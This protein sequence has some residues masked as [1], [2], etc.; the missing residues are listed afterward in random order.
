MKEMK[1]PDCGGALRTQVDCM[2]HAK[3]CPGY[4]RWL[5]ERNREI[6]ELR[7]RGFGIRAIAERFG[8]SP[9]LVCHVLKRSAPKELTLEEVI[10]A[11]KSPEAL[12]LFLLQ[13][14]VKR[15]RDLEEENEALKRK[16]KE[17]EE[18]LK[19]LRDEHNSAL[20]AKK[21]SNL[22]IDNAVKAIV[23]KEG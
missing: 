10:R 15:I 5:E 22:T 4:R 3:T 19:K 12:G 8:V 20:A 1:C 21:L 17:L 23:R 11:F 18:L 16:V 7:N 14:F 2:A 6:V 9:G 13:G